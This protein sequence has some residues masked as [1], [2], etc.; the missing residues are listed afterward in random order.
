MVDDTS[1]WVGGDGV[2][3]G[4]VSVLAECARKSYL[5]DEIAG[6]APS[7]RA[8]ET[9]QALPLGDGENGVLLCG[10]AQLREGPSHPLCLEG[11]GKSAR[12]TG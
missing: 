8:I 12:S 2:G 3:P 10:R 5:E 11:K 7:M 6:G 4:G 1:S 9:P